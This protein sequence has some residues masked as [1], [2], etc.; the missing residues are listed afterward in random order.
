MATMR[1]EV[2]LFAVARDLAA[3]D[4]LTVELQQGATVA[5]LRQK[6][7]ELLPEL[8]P[9]ASQLLFAVDEQYTRDTTVLEPNADVACIPPVSGG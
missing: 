9:M 6:L 2:R 8:S 4:H 5:D 1:L 7:V 3:S